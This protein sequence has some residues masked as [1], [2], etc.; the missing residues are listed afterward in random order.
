LSTL[1][2]QFW[3]FMKLY[4]FSAVVNIFSNLVFFRL[5][6]FTHFC[7]KTK[8]SFLAWFMTSALTAVLN[9]LGQTL[10]VFKTPSLPNQ[11]IDR[12]YY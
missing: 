1:P 12:K 6:L 3:N 10:W 4:S 2:K 11:L 7:P 9:Y 8:V 5:L